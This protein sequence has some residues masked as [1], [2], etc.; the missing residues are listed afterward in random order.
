MDAA[1]FVRANTVLGT[2]SHV[3]EIRLHL[4]DD[5]MPLWH[6]TEEELAEV[7]LPAPF[8]AFA[9]AGGQALAR[10]VLDHAAI[11]SGRRVLDLGAGSGIAGIA[12]AIA[13][14]RHVVPSELDR[15]A[16]AAIG[17][18]AAANNVRLDATVGDILGE[19]AEADLV[20]AG[21]IFYERPLAE[22]A[23]AFLRRAQ[24]DGAEV[25]IGDPRRTYLPFEALE[26]VVTYSI[27]VP[28][29]LEDMDVKKTTV[30]RLK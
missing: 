16:I 9:W 27:T 20:L 19:A 2:P 5:A 12:A 23:F 17:M 25:L 7:G 24:A 3:P 18:N 15:F 14:A 10:Y 11:A 6:K 22:R 26:P 21:D 29:A 1:E 13:G 28:L 8:W 4:A 30:W